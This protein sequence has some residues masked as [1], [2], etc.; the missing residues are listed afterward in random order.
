MD[1]REH[2]QRALALSGSLSILADQEKLDG[3]EDGC[4]MLDGILR[5][6]AYKIRGAAGELA[7]PRRHAGNRKGRATHEG[8]FENTGGMPSASPLA[9]ASAWGRDDGLGGRLRRRFGGRGV[10]KRR[11]VTHEARRR[12]VEIL[13]KK[14]LVVRPVRRRKFL[15]PCCPWA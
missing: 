13:S 9:R 4:L 2:I 7:V 11:R 12:Q 15:R 1:H 14:T 10:A 5:D 6:C 3:E 8:P